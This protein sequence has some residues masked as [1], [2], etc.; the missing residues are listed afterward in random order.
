ME[1]QE[2]REKIDK[3][4]DS[5]LELF[6]ERM[7]LSAE[8]AAVKAQSGQPILNKAREREVLLKVSRCAGVELESY[9]ACSSIRSLK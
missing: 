8:V 2:I 4:D 6:R 5:L 9:A 3:V 7:A 1:L